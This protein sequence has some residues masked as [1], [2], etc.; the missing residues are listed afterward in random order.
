MDWLNETL[1]LL[2]NKHAYL[3]ASFDSVQTLNDSTTLAILYLG[4]KFEWGLINVSSINKQTLAQIGYRAKQFQQ[5]TINWK[6]WQALQNKLLNYYE[7]HG[8]PF[9][10]VYLSDISFYQESDTYYF[11]ASLQAERKQYFT[12]DSLAIYGTAN[13][14]QRFLQNYLNIKR[15][16][17]YNELQ[18][19]KSSNRIRELAFVKEARVPS[20][21]FLDKRAVVSLYL[22]KQKASRFDFLLGV[23]PQS[24]GNGQQQRYQ[25]T[26]DGTLN[27]QNA[28]GQGELIDLTFKS[29][30]NQTRELTTQ[31]LYPYLPV[32]PIGADFRFKLYLRDSTFRD[33]NINFG[34]QYAWQGNNFIKTS[35]ERNSSIL[36]TADSAQLVN[37][38]SL[39][40][41]LDLQQTLY[42]IAYQIERLDYRINPRKGIAVQAAIA[43]GNKKIIAN[44]A[45][46]SIGEAAEIDFK[47]QYDSLNIN[48]FQYKV[49]YKIDGY[50]PLFKN[51][52]IRLA[53]QGGWIANNNILLNELYRIG[54]NRDLRGF[55][56]Q[57]LLVSMYHIAHL[58]Y[59]F[60]IGTN[61]NMF[62]F[63]NMAYLENKS[64][65]SNINDWPMGFGVGMNLETQAGIFG[66]TY[67]LGRQQQNAFNF[68]N[69][70]IHFGYVNYF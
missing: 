24:G 15:G 10:E 40:E 19:A 58:E 66:L 9:A 68:R 49:D 6:Q 62:A 52:T 48:R 21:A 22:K 30:P 51:S 59:R 5:Q 4:C 70:K 34:L 57:S 39:P 50:I 42:G 3:A 54:G 55:D 20:V 31:L 47:A 65:G 28:L 29:Y 1:S 27:L 37:T 16:Q 11:S 46:L 60:L 8:F 26:G 69:G 33:V 45:I 61:S 7:N 17:A 64:R 25:I 56:E 2:R 32:V 63:Y 36:L 35:I 41:A 67:A 23:L 14:K 44:N 53:A 12:I 38:A 18:I 13:I 43:G